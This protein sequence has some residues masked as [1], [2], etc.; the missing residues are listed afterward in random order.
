[1]AAIAAPPVEVPRPRPVAPAWHTLALVALFL[2]VAAGGAYF[3]SRASAHPAI[4]ERHAGVLPL[5]GSL[6]ILEWGLLYYIWKG[7]LRR[8]GTALSELI[9]ERWGHGRDVLA[10]AAW[11]G[12]LWAAWMLL[13]LGWRRWLAPGAAASVESMLP[14]SGLE[15][16]LWIVLSVS[17]G[18]CEEL[19]FRGYFQRQFHALTGRRWVAVVLQSLLFGISHGY[20]GAVA[21]LKIALYGAMFG[22]FALWRR[23]LRP[24][25]IAHAWTDIATGLLFR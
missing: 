9:G 3:Q 18:V 19:V 21:C 7:G 17:A 25:M 5:Y 23:S 4:A 8:T 20:Q 11:A 24:G 12:A 1:M 15:T 14:R 10:D 22:A 13:L 6:I 2:I 16:V